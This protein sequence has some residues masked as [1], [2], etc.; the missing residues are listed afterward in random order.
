M[1][2][3]ARLP[4]ENTTWNPAEY[5]ASRI[6]H[7][8]PNGQSDLVAILGRNNWDRMLRLAKAREQKAQQ[9]VEGNKEQKA[10][11]SVSRSEFHDSGLGTSIATPSSYAETVVSYHGSKGGSIKIPPLPAEAAGGKPFICGVCG[12]SI[13]ISN[14]TLWKY[15]SVSLFGMR[16][17]S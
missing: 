11:T 7:R 4:E 12:D 8:Y 6:R 10:A 1:E 16:H 3:V 2:K 17:L 5:L 13:K 14:T 9:P 15:V